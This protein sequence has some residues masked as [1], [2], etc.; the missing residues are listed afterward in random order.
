MINKTITP[1][2][3]CEYHIEENHVHKCRIVSG[4]PNVLSITCYRHEEKKEENKMTEKIKETSIKGACPKCGDAD[5]LVLREIE[6]ST[7]FQYCS[8]CQ[9]AEDV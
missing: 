1:C 7:A 4:N 9:W 8:A 5:H 6:D 2:L 3:T